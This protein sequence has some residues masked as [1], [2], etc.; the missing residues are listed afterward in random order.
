[1][2]ARTFGRFSAAVRSGTTSSRGAH[3]SNSAANCSSGTSVP[4]NSPVDASTT[5][6]PALPS[7]TTKAAR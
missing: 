2:V 4:V 1:M 3:R 5:A 6:T 7:L